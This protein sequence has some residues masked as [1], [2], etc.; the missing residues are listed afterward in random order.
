MLA[1]AVHREVVVDLEPFRRDG[2]HC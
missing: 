1:R 2:L